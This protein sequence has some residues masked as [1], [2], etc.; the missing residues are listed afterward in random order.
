MPVDHDYSR[1]AEPAH[2][3]PMITLVMRARNGDERAW[4]A[5]VERYAPD[6]TDVPDDQ[7][8][9]AEQLLTAERHAAMRQA[10][11]QLPPLLPAT[12]H[13]AH[14]GPAHPVRRDQR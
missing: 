14:Q 2:S 3:N 11:A 1:D 5:L 6:V 13:P 10:L 9:A 4:A 7:P 8:S 12:A